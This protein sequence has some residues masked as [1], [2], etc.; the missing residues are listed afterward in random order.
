[1]AI[2]IERARRARC[3]C[4]VNLMPG[5]YRV[6]CLFDQVRDGYPEKILGETRFEVPSNPGGTVQVACA[7]GASTTVGCN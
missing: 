1:M 2:A 7:C 5:S 3:C 6:Q 4:S